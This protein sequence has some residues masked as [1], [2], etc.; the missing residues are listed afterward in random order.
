MAIA[1]AMDESLP[2]QDRPRGD[3]DL[4]DPGGLDDLDPA[5]RAGRVEVPSPLPGVARGHA[6]MVSAASRTPG[7]CRDSR[8]RFP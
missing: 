1:D 6:A 2:E 7:E 4:V 3:T 5:G 8:N